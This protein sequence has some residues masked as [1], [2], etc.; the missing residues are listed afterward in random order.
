MPSLLYVWAE[1]RPSVALKEEIVDFFK[2]QI[3]VHHPKG[4]KTQDT[5]RVFLFQTT[6]YLK[7]WAELFVGL[8]TDI[9]I[10]LLGAHAED[11]TRW[12]SLLYDLYDALIRE[13][14]HIGSRG[15]YVTGSRHI[16]VK[17]GLIELMA[18]ICHQVMMQM[19]L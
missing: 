13:I 16:A 6:K 18:D 17:D 9:Q 2:L 14:S 15:K 7:S 5:G 11:W 10:P 4:A 12:R 19:F 1:M 8:L 3:C